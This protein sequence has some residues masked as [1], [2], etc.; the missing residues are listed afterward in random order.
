MNHSEG[1]RSGATR[2]AWLAVAVAA[3]AAA[4]TPVAAVTAIT[5]GK[6]S[7]YV[8]GDNVAI[9]TGLF[10]GTPILSGQLLKGK[11]KTVIAI[12]VT[13]SNFNPSS[14]AN[15]VTGVL[16]RVNFT[17]AE[18]K[19]GSTGWPSTQTCPPL[20]FCS[21]TALFFF[22]V[23][24][25]ELASPGTFVGQPLT[26]DLWAVQDGSPTTLPYL[27]IEARVQKK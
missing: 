7:I 25:A 26:V 3:V 11:K 13:W 19:Q 18:P 22:D 27:A 6:Q 16:P 4:A 23:D 17:Y 10:F 21:S 14:S 8:S 24:A 5:P 20:S 9:P 15:A 2:S 12:T 1:T